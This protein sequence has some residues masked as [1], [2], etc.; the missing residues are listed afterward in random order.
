MPP[1]IRRQ[2]PHS[3][4]GPSMEG[5]S[6][7]STGTWPSLALRARTPMNTRPPLGPHGHR[8]LAPLAALSA[9]P[10]TATEP[11]LAPSLAHTTTG[12]C[13]R[14]HRGRPALGLSRSSATHAW[15]VTGGSRPSRCRQHIGEEHRSA[16]GESTVAAL[17]HSATPTGTRPPLSPYTAPLRDSLAPLRLPRPHAWHPSPRR[18]PPYSLPQRLSGPPAG[19][20]LASQPL[21]PT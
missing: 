11:P 6:T 21:G 2:P 20:A 7:A 17:S 3:A 13:R 1:I 18:P 5:G 15:G 14:E 9:Q 10:P 19:T 4:L 12:C 16:A 8:V